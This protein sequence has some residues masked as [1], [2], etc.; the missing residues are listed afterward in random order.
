MGMYDNVNFKCSCP[1]CGAKVQGFQTKEG[2]CIL[3]TLTPFEISFCYN[4]CPNCNSW[5][6]IELDNPSER[7]FQAIAY[8]N[9]NGTDRKKLI[10]TEGVVRRTCEGDFLAEETHKIMFE[11]Y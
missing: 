9:G 2:P 1:K 7:S 10:G 3:S 8:E 5:I 6:E 11:D 4:S